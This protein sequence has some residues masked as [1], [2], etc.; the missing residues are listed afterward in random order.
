MHRD[1]K[2][3]SIRLTDEEGDPEYTRL[4]LSMW[5]LYT[6]TTYHNFLSKRAF[7]IHREDA[8]K[9]MNKLRDYIIKI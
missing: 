2:E 1:L 5:R 4:F 7:D 9:L 6:P 3:L 8:I